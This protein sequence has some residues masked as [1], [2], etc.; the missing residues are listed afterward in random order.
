MQCKVAL[1]HRL[2]RVVVV[3]GDHELTCRIFSSNATN[4]KDID[5]FTIS[6]TWGV[7][8][9]YEKVHLLCQVLPGVNDKSPS[10]YFYIFGISMTWGLSA[11]APALSDVTRCQ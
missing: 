3:G 5:V 8:N 7:Q 11:G 10:T 1:A 4:F 6:M 9:R 2:I